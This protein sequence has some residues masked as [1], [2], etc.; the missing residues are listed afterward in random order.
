MIHVTVFFQ[1]SVWDRPEIRAHSFKSQ[2]A[3]WFT[4]AQGIE[5]NDLNMRVAPYITVRATCFSVPNCMKTHEQNARG[6][7]GCQLLPIPLQSRC[8]L[9]SQ[10]DSKTFGPL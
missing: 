4:A 10:A 7:T 3:E 8:V 1:L 2:R 6:Q 5:R 9:I